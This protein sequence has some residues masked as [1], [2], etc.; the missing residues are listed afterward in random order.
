MLKFVTYVLNI[1]HNSSHS[2]K[3][4]GYRDSYIFLIAFFKFL[5]FLMKL[6]VLG[7]C[8]YYFDIFQWISVGLVS[9]CLKTI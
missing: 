1:E 5:Y 4:A 7:H 6:C 9:L 8:E 2:I 3:F